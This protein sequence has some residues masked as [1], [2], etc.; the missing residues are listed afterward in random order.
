MGVGYESLESV[1]LYSMREGVDERLKHEC[2]LLLVPRC[3][4]HIDRRAFS[5]SVQV[6]R[7]QIFR[8]LPGCVKMDEAG[9]D[10]RHTRRQE[11]DTAGSKLEEDVESE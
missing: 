10:Y 3:G 7:Q 4:A 8:L 5:D 9:C 6:E 11:K 2:V 1:G